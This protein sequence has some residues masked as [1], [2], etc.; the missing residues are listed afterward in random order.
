MI[1]TLIFKICPGISNF[2]MRGFSN[3]RMWRNFCNRQISSLTF[4]TIRHLAGPPQKQWHVV[5]CLSYQEKVERM[6][7]QPM[8]LTLLSLIHSILT[9]ASTPLEHF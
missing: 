4:R 9:H 6:N 7:M 8:G 5:L 3:G 1:K 2:E